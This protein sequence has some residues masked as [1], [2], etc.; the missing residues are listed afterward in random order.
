MC[1]YL[2]TSGLDS[3][4]WIIDNINAISMSIGNTSIT[5]SHNLYHNNYISII[6]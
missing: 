3:Q 6:Y 4:K 2:N 1:N 5:Y